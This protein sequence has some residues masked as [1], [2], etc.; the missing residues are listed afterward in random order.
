MDG[1]WL[2]KCILIC[3][4]YG[5]IIVVVIVVVVV[6]VVV[7]VAVTNAGIPVYVG[8]A[9]SRICLFVHTV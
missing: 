7:V 1:A 6:V 8:R 5:A 2:I 4:S 3:D 9:F